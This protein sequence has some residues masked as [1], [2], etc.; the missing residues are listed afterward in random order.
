MIKSFLLS[1]PILLLLNIAVLSQQQGL[2]C[3]NCTNAV[4]GEKCSSAGTHCAGEDPNAGCVSEGGG[5]CGCAR[6]FHQ[7]TSSTS[8][9]GLN[10]FGG[11]FNPKRR[12]LTLTHAGTIPD[13]QPGDEIHGIGPTSPL[14][15]TRNR[16]IRYTPNRPA[17]RLRLRVYRPS[18]GTWLNINWR[19]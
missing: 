18:T 16:I 17:R 10:W 3:S 5:C 4:W 9:S 13:L 15:T 6:G 8:R 19:G 1:L 7:G 12:V 11:S 2:D 14:R